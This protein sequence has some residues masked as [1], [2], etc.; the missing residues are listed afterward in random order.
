[1]KN[2]VIIGRLE[3]DSA[4]EVLNLH[5]ERAGEASAKELRRLR[6]S[7]K[8]TT[9]K[10]HATEAGNGGTLATMAKTHG[11]SGPGISPLPSLSPNGLLSKT[12]QMQRPTTPEPSNPT[13]VSKL[14]TVERQN[15]TNYIADG[16]DFTVY[17]PS[18]TPGPPRTNGSVAMCDLYDQQIVASCNSDQVEDDYNEGVLDLAEKTR[19]GPPRTT[20]K[21]E[22]LELSR[23]KVRD[24]DRKRRE[25]EAKFDDAVQAAS[26]AHGIYR[27]P[28]DQWPEDWKEQLN[29]SA[30]RLAKLGY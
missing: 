17:L 27:G 8:F 30:S 7:K 22:S 6:F 26:A 13:E 21:R 29:L 28:R 24:F 14:A 23:N 19:A 5:F 10:T 11:D 4:K 1:M 9:A 3:D 12:L 25:A 18:P 16:S 15:R 2:L 20:L